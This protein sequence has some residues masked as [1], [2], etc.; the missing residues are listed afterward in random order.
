MG[1]RAG[2]RGL[3]PPRLDSSRAPGPTLNRGSRHPDRSTATAPGRDVL[4]AE[5]GVD[6]EHRHPP[7]HLHRAA[8]GVRSRDIARVCPVSR[9][10]APG[11]RA[12]CRFQVGPNVAGWR[13]SGPSDQDKLGAGRR[14]QSSQ[15][16]CA[17]S[18]GTGPVRGCPGGAGPGQDR[19]DIGM[20][21]ARWRGQG[22]GRCDI[23]HALGP[24]RIAFRPRRMVLPGCLAARKV[25]PSRAEF[26]DDIGLLVFLAQGR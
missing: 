12:A 26:E 10:T 20:D 25:R 4:P 3:G 2:T 7:D 1:P 18:R 15:T 6:V 19:P 16:L 8:P 22:M 9:R 14:V 5:A 23:A 13:E 17:S 21:H 11:P 24:G